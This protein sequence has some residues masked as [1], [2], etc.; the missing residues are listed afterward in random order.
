MATAGFKDTAPTF[1]YSQR[2]LNVTVHTVSDWHHIHQNPTSTK[3][4][5]ATLAQFTLVLPGRLVALLTG[6]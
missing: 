4:S 5:E 6:R 1:P 3:N 2:D